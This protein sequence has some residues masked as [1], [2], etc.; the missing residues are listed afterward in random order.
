[1]KVPLLDLKEQYRALKPEIDA[2]I[3]EVMESQQFILGP[4]VQECEEAI[5]RYSGSSFAVGVS[6]GTDAL[7][8]CLMAEDIGPGDEVIT[9]PYTFFA[10]GGSIARTGATPVFVDIDPV[11]YNIDI[12]Q[13]ESKVTSR[14]RAVIPVHLYGQMADMDGILEVARRQGLVIIEDAAQAIGAEYKGRRAGSLG[15]YGCFSFFPSKNLGAAGDGGMVVTD[16]SD[17]AEKLRRLRAHGSKP[18]YYHRFIGGNFRLD[19]LQAAV[20]TAKLKHL[21]AWTSARQDNA[22]RYNMHFAASGLSV[23]ASSAYDR[24]STN[25]R[26]ALQS[27]GSGKIVPTLFLPSVVTDRHIFNQYVIRVAGRDRLKAA[28]EAKGVATEIYYPLPLHLQECF[29]HLGHAEGDFPESER[30]AS[31]T[32]ALPIFP[33]LTEEQV[34]YVVECVKNCL[35]SK[36]GAHGE[37]VH[38]SLDV[39]GHTGEVSERIAA[40]K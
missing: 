20:V 3:A 33:E 5:A 23:S 39:D 6:S 12:T 38:P 36:A 19:S 8:I 1:M 7:L 9:T 29:A 28:L 34:Q 35:L 11:T 21:D 32:L 24:N 27:T 15:D 37:P 14:T 31:E 18:K 25:E 30:A 16:D 10:T 22:R 4:K 40:S 2:A 26:Q 13:L 17:R